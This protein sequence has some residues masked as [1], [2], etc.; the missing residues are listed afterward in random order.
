MNRVLVNTSPDNGIDMGWGEEMFTFQTNR[1]SF[2]QVEP[3]VTMFC[4]HSSVALRTPSMTKTPRQHTYYLWKKFPF[5]FDFIFA[6]QR[7]SVKLKARLLLYFTSIYIYIICVYMYILTWQH[8][9]DCLEKIN[10]NVIGSF[11][12]LSSLSLRILLYRTFTPASNH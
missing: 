6:L 2:I 7:C 9:K 8:S 5:Y 11:Y 4:Y 3:P 1:S 12:I 10:T